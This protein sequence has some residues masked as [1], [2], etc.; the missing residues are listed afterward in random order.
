MNI[1]NNPPSKTPRW[2]R[3]PLMWLPVITFVTA[4]IL[5]GSAWREFGRPAEVS[6]VTLVPTPTLTP[7]PSDPFAVKLLQQM[8][9]AMNRLKTLKVIEVLRDDSGHAV[10]TTIL[11]A[12][13]DTVSVRL[14]TGAE[15]IRIN[16]MQW[17]REAQ[18]TLWRA[19]ESPKPFVFPDYRFYS[20]QA[21]D[22][23]LG[24]ATVLNGLPARSVTFAFVGFDGRFDFVLYS[25][26]ETLLFRR[27]T[28]EGPGH[29]MVTDF[30]DYGPT[31]SVT[32]P[33]AELIAPTP[34][35]L[36]P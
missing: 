31:V 36:S 4:A 5:F 15:S 3:D 7:E 17:T 2:W 20:S 9:D 19:Y 35:A 22:V 25:D 32:E 23:Q 34:T 10:T 1:Q 27:L 33:P 14:S 13:P 26:P 28:M 29:H 21:V 30:V 6:S 12:A 8:E 18:E 11:Y 16:R 24:S